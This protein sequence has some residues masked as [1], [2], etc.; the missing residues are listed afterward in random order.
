MRTIKTL[1]VIGS[2]AAL[3]L[4]MSAV[5]AQATAAGAAG[6]RQIADPNEAACLQYLNRAGYP[7]TTA[8]MQ[9]C[10]WGLYSFDNC[11]SFLTSRAGVSAVHARRACYLAGI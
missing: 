7:T 9:G 5:P 4:G 10:N 8:T 11:V 6:S 1:A 3:A 2:L